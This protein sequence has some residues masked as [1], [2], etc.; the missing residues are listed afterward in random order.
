[1]AKILEYPK[2]KPVVCCDC[3]CKYELENGDIIRLIIAP[4]EIDDEIHGKV[5]ACGISFGLTCPICGQDNK[6]ER[7][8]ND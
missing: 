6:I 1:M 4:C 7:E 8:D 5:Q 2:F 3:G